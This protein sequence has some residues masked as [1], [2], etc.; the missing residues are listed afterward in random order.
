MGAVSLA[1]APPPIPMGTGTGIGVVDL[2][3]VAAA[4]AVV[5]SAIVVFQL[6]GCGGGA[7]RCLVP[8]SG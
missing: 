2:S 5:S 8:V 1:V 4:G 7:L 3:G 6:V